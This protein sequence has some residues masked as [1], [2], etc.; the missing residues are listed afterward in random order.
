VS[1]VIYMPLE[2]EGA[3]CWRPVHADHVSGDVYEITVLKEPGEEHWRFPPGSTVCCTE[4]VFHD[5]ERG[6]VAYELVS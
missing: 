2:D 5:G 4:H 6:L 3:D 1:V